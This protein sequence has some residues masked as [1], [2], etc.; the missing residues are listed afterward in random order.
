LVTLGSR[1][2][3]TTRRAATSATIPTGR[4]TR[5]TQRQ[6]AVTSRP[7]NTGPAAAASPATADQIRTYASR[8]A[9]GIAPSSS[10]SEVGVSA[11]A[12]AA[13]N[14]R[15]ATSHHRPGAAAHATLASVNTSRPRENIRLR[16]IL[17]ASRPNGTS[18]AA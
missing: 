13:C 16:P 1:E 15:N 10:P 7:P 9:A 17:S 14:T 5:N 2:S 4:F 3:G 11:A 6:L 8:F 12:P 18:S